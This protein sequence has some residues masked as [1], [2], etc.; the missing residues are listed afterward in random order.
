MVSEDRT[1]EF[2][3]LCD[4][5][6]RTAPP[7]KP[8]PTKL[9]LLKTKEKQKIELAQFSAVTSRV[10]KEIY[11]TVVKL[12]KLTQLASKTNL[13]DDPTL[14]IQ[15]LTNI[16]KKDIWT[17]QRE[18][19]MLKENDEE[20][21]NSSEQLSVHS[22]HV[23]DSLETKLASTSQEF[24][25]ILTVRAQ[26]MKLQHETSQQFSGAIT[27][28][29]NLIIDPSSFKLPESREIR[30]DD[31]E[32]G[33]LLPGGSQLFVVQDERETT[34]ARDLRKIE[35]ILGELQGLFTQFADVLAT[36][37]EQITRIDA[38]V[39][40]TFAQVEGVQEQLIKYFQKISDNKW[41]MTQI[42]LVLLVT[43]II[44][45]VFFV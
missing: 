11:N 14:E 34:R 40:E 23:L 6:K 41:L 4:A 39:E 5:A 10:G 44:F 17:L 1:H 2:F 35:E 37:R 26:N 33:I 16:I 9:T 38:N 24:K 13:F 31:Q 45:I 21:L 42:F 8:T 12:K 32:T 36:Q 27:R 28:S 25:K 7:S 30:D 19:K 20:K 18:L 29:S 15:E 43:V 3:T 22:K